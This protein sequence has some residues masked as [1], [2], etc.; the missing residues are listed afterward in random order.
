[1]SRRRGDLG[2]DVEREREREEREKGHGMEMHAPC[3]RHRALSAKSV[4]PLTAGELRGGIAS[5]R[6]TTRTD[7]MREPPRHQG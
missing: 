3:E 7:P 5:R 4:H 6:V 1:M 2:D